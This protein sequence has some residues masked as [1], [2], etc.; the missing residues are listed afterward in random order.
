[1]VWIKT[2]DLYVQVV[3]LKRELDRRGP[4]GFFLY[5]RMGIYITVRTTGGEC[6]M[7]DRACSAIANLRVNDMQLGG[8]RV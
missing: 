6:W 1:M 4:R 5:G 8:W 7:D 2:F 3:F